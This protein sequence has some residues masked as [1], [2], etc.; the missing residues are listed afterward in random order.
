MNRPGVLVLLAVG[1]IALPLAAG[2][3][4]KSRLAQDFADREN[5]RR[6]RSM[7]ADLRWP[8]WF[9][10]MDKNDDG[11]LTRIE[12]IGT[13]EQFERVDADKDGFISPREASAADDWFR[14]QVPD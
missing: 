4:V 6:P 7:G 8:D 11:K 13:D 10:T 3:V 2:F 5:D 9:R 1:V 14:S 12:F